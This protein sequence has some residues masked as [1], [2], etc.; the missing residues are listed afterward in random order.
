MT[1]PATEPNIWNEAMAQLDR[2]A[3]RMSL[4]AY[5]VERLRHPKRSLLVSLPVKMDDGSVRVFEGCR[6]QHNVDRGPAKGGVRFHPSVELDEVKA[7]AFW[8]TMKCAV[9]NL[10]FGGAKGGVVCDPKSL[11]EGELERLTRRYAAEL[12]ILIG[13][14]K[15]IPAPDVNTNEKVMG[16]IM[17]TYS[18]IQGHSVPGVVTGKPVEIGGTLGR[19]E[20]TGRGLFF[21]VQELARQKG[22]PLSGLRAVVQGFGNVGSNVA[23]LLSEAGVKVVAVADAG[24]GIVN[25]RGLDV[26]ALRLYAGA[27]GAQERSVAGFPGGEKATNAEV[28]ETACDVLLPCAM[29]NQITAANAARVKAAFVV[30]G[31]NGPTTGE[32]DRILRERGVL[33]VPD[34]LANAGG[35]TVSYFEWVQDI[36]SF[37]WEEGEIND[38]LKTL[39]LRAF[40]DVSETAEREK[41]DLRLAAFMVALKRLSLA[42]AQRGIFP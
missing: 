27:P 7:L 25:P 15:D 38:R 16:W 40:K 4:P 9:V 6:V 26:E 14:D 11:S 35:V 37:F 12:S 8:M 42:I 13:P 34:I 28:L 22:L 3:S 5:V 19:R 29:E 1:D 17:D 32:A 20:A 23:R 24:G 2:A 41:V 39:M 10:P 36:Q 31:A 21:I 33:V 18:S 30:E